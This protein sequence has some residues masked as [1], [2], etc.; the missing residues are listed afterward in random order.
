M[1][2]NGAL[3]TNP[4]I[5]PPNYSFG[6]NWGIF[7]KW[8]YNLWAYLSKFE[9]GTF[10]PVLR[11]NNVTGGVTFASQYGQFTR[12]GNRVFVEISVVLSNKGVSVGDVTIV[13]LPYTSYDG[14]TT[15]N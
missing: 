7:F 15:Q 6:R 1:T 2:T 10:I 12:I 4:Q 14:I 13:D 8:L 5:E 11:I 3:I 9:Q